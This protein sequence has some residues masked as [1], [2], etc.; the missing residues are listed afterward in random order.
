MIPLSV[1]K[2]IL[3]AFGS[4]LFAGMNDLVFKRQATSGH[5][6]GQYMAIVG[7]VWTIVFVLLAITGGQTRVAPAAITW[8]LVAG[9]FS[10][11][12][13]YLLIA[14]LRRL[15]ASV[16]AT[17]YR[18]NLVVA[19]FL[20]IF[21]F[22]EPLT[23]RKIVGLALA[24]VAVFL[25]AEKRRGADGHAS[26]ISKG[27]VLAIVAS[28]LRAG[29]GLTYKFA[30]NEF[31]SLEANGLTPQYNWF[32]AVQG[33]MWLALGLFA[34]MR[35]EGIVKLTWPNIRFGVLSGFL[36]CGIVLFM[37]WALAAGQ[38]SVVIPITQMSFLVTALLSWPI[39]RERFGPRKITA[40]A[41]A[42]TALLFLSISPK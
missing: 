23:P 29:M 36:V 17:I 8:G 3:F 7:A 24:C 5:G 41:L 31:A 10:V 2:S 25:F 11:L 1:D 38:A 12:G 15:D 13:N 28:F 22:G 42:A 18:L 19:A 14:S 34:S 16:G 9:I 32:L 40:L 39:I 21:L 27:L 30:T 26:W 4:L 33:L 6:R 37:A 20:A 35:F